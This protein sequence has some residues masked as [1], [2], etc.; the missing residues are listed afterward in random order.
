MKS[1]SLQKAFAVILLFSISLITVPTKTQNA[2][3]ATLEEVNGKIDQVSKNLEAKR[4]EATSLQNQIDIIDGQ[5]AQLQLQMEATQIEIETTTQKI[6]EVEVELKKQQAVLNEHLRV[7][8]EESNTSPMEQ[9]AS[10]NSF[11]DFADK[12]E[13]LQVMQGEIKTAME[14]IKKLKNELDQKKKSLDEMKKSQILQKQ[15]MDQQ[16]ALKDSLLAKANSDAAGLQNQ[17]DDLYAQKAALSVQFGEG[18]S[19][20][21][22]GYPF[23]NPPPRNI[24]DTPDPWGYLIGEC[25]S[26]VAWK[27]AAAGRPVPR[28][29]GNAG[30]WAGMANGGPT[31]GAVAVFPYIGGYGHVAIVEAVYGNGTILISEYNWIPYSFSTRVINPYNYGTVYIN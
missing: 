10:S 25:T 28:A 31:P 13:Y 12:S 1:S 6:K 21:S 29:A 18:I 19:R 11:A 2:E 9:I 3:A 30:Q 15:G 26:Y 23:G 24:I 7:I 5:V 22:S 14:K 27:R 20:G 16:K 4:G 8:Y 17:L